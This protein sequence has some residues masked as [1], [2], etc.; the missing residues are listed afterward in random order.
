LEAIGLREYA[1]FLEASTTG[2]T[3]K[4]EA[5]LPRRNRRNG[6]GIV[7]FP[8]GGYGGLA[9]HEGK[10]FAEFFSAKGFASFV[11]QYRL[12]SQGHRHPAMLEDALAA[13]ATVR[14]HAA[15]LGLRKVGVMGSSAGGHLAAHAAVDWNRYQSAVPLR[16]DFA[17]LCY[18][19]IAMRGPFCHRGSRDNLIGPKP[20]ARRIREVSCLDRVSADTPPC[21]L[22]HTWED[23]ALP[24][25]NTMLFAAALRTHKVPFELH[26]YP[27]GGH[28]LALNTRLPWAEQCMRWMKEDVTT[29]LNT[30]H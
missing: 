30:E 6:I 9:D 16:P 15:E 14:R 1:G 13:I 19:V 29:D 5:W 26:I 20:P 23:P 7:I 25:D 10:A 2:A 8:G 21:F 12:G 4:I 18:P 3:P 22:W 11:V 28:G 24:M 27:H 17:V